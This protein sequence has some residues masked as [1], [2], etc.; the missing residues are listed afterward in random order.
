MYF[1]QLRNTTSNELRT[2]VSDFVVAVP[3]W[4]TDTQRRA[5]QDAASIAGMNALRIINDATAVALGYGITKA[6]LPDADNPRHVMFVDVGHSSMTVTIVA[7]SKG[8]LVVKG[9][10]WDINLGGREIDHKLLEH[11]AEEFKEKYKIDILSSPKATFRLATGCERLKKILSANTNAPLNVESVMND[12]DVSSKLSREHYEALISPILDRI[13]API[14]AALERSKLTLDQIDSVE[15]VGGTTRVPAVRARIQAVL[16]GKS[17][18]TTVN[19]DEACARGAT[20]ACAFHSPTFRVRE[21]S[22]KD[23]AH[24]D[25][26]VCWDY[27]PEDPD[28]DTQLLV[29]ER[30]AQVPSTKI[31]TFYRK[32]DFNIFAEY[33]DPNL[34]PGSINP[35]FARF[36]SKAAPSPSLDVTCIKV[37]TRMTPSGMLRFEEAY[38]VEEVGEEP[39]MEVDGVTGQAAPP[40]KKHVKK[41]VPFEADFTSLDSVTIEKFRELEAQMHATDKLVQDTEVLSLFVVLVHQ[42]ITCLLQDCRNALEEYLYDMRGKLD[43]RYAAYVTNDEKE[44]FLRALQGSE[45]WLDSEEDATKSTYIANL[46]A[47]KAFGDPI[48]TRYRED[49]DR[50]GAISQLRQSVNEY[51]AQATSTE[52][53]YA[54]IEEKTKQTVVEKCATV[55]KWL[56]DQVARQAERPKNENPILTVADIMKKRDEL[57]YFAV[58]VLTKPKPKPVKVETTPAGTPTGGRTP[59]NETQTPEQ[60]GKPEGGQ[61]PSEMDVD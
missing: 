20:F 51:L 43:E 36:T 14:Q 41:V 45:N 27:L 47:L 3:C 30:Q 56:D 52:E 59:P 54:H 29:F 15:L 46:D 17:L 26:N 61:G 42:L 8:Q 49:N 1:G 31:L 24:Y 16:G 10:A 48:V 58:P 21:F 57:I 53:K 5:I 25:V 28:D 32:E 19:Q 40:K 44:R 11:F 7:F 55:Q 2:P 6:D 4:F 33:A 22:I 50:L 37:K 34:L 12:V 38:V 9:S 35:R 13:A 39:P 23:I 18:S 60:G